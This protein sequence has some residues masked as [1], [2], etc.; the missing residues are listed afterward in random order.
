[1]SSPALCRFIPAVSRLATKGVV[2]PRLSVK[3]QLRPWAY[4]SGRSFSA[5]PALLVK[6]YTED[7]EWIELDSDGKTGTIGITEYAAKALGDVVYVELPEIGMEVTKGDT[8]G[9]VESVKSASD[10]MTPVSG[11]ISDHNK[12]LE[13]KPGTINKSPES[14][15]WLAKIEVTNLNELD[16]LMSKEDYDNFEKE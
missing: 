14:E 16:G 2:V 8:I 9:A 3:S 15:G 1:M 6:K 7:H 4:L 12:L 10:I 5:R 11:K 13:E